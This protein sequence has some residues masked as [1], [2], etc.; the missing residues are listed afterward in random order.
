MDNSFIIVCL[1]LVGMVFIPFF[2]F[3]S[4]GKSETK[5]NSLLIAKT[6]ADKGLKITHSELWGHHYIGMDVEQHKILFLKISKSD[7]SEVLLDL[8]YVEDLQIA[9][10]R[11]MVRVDSKKELVLQKLDLEVSMKNGEKRMF[12]FYDSA[13]FEREDYELHRIQK[14]KAMIFKQLSNVAYER[15]IA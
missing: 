10:K 13:Q 3:N 5:K 12:N 8:K 14:W 7:G 6:I 1:V 9:E 2:L 11:K 4:A 15:Q